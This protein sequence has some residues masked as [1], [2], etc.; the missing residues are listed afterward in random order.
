MTGK[1]PFFRTG[2][3]VTVHDFMEANG[4]P[5]PGR[6]LCDNRKSNYGQV[7]VVLIDLGD[8]EMVE[9]FKADGTRYIPGQRLHITLGWEGKEG[10][11]SP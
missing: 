4:Q 1:R 10:M 11:P 8:Q 7:L 6:V 5:V 2:D 9:F 3:R